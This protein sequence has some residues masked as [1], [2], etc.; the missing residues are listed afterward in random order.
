[1]VSRFIEF[2]ARE[3]YPQLQVRTILRCSYV[4]LI[5]TLDFFTLDYLLQFE[6]SWAV[7]NIASVISDNTKIVVEYGVLPIFA[8]LL[9][10]RVRMFA[11]R[12]VTNSCGKGII[13]L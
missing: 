12:N 8:K 1:M 7:T 2:L 11:S 6:A 9:S 3:D 13:V 10:S 5:D 4:D